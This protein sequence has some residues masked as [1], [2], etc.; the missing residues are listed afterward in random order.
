MG[1]E[2]TILNN[3]TAIQ[4]GGLGL[5]S[6]NKLFQ[7]KP[8]TLTVVQPNSQIEGAIKG[9]LRISET[10]DQFDEMFCTLL[11]Q[12]SE[13]RQ[14]HIGNASEMNRTFEN[15]MCFSRDMVKP[16]PKSKIPQ[17]VNCANCARSDWGPWREYK[18]ANGGKTNKALI[19][20]CDPRYI[21]VFLDTV[22]QLPLKMYLRSKSR[23]E[24]EIATQNIAR[25]IAMM[26]AQGL[27][28][29]VF[30]VR[31]KITT[32]EIITGPYKTYVPK[33]TDFKRITDEEREKFG[34]V[35]FQYLES[36]KPKKTEDKQIEQQQAQ[37]DAVIEGD[38]VQ[39]N[40]DDIP[41]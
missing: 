29:N 12:P 2:L 15:L 25:V 11:V 24:F 40:D 35:Y 6:S 4:E 37:Q 20:P 18:E 8:G 39:E 13:Q 10:G 30:D 17:A 22:Y 32:K 36:I 34:A 14:Y 23:S 26:K 41:F 27:K 28:P 16:D 1:T 21:A 19:P 33:F 7:V 31:F 5:E 9:K 3:E 38:Y